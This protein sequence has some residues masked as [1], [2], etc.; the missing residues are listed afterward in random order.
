[1]AIPNEQT[2]SDIHGVFIYVGPPSEEDSVAPA[3]LGLINAIAGAVRFQLL[4]VAVVSL[5]RREVSHSNLEQVHECAIVAELL[6]PR[7][8]VHRKKDGLHH[9][10]GFQ[11]D[12]ALEIVA[13][14]VVTTFLGI[15]P[16]SHYSRR[17]QS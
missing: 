17:T 15:D 3:Q 7:A 2:L 14:L 9:C 16:L 11:I 10:L 12:K 8:R 13:L 1:M 4:E 5:T 6:N